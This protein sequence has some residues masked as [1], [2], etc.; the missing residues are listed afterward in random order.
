[1]LARRGR[2]NDEV[3]Q[4]RPGQKKTVCGCK[5]TGV[6]SVLIPRQS[7]F[8]SKCRHGDVLKLILILPYFHPPT[9]AGDNGI[10]RIGFV[11]LHLT[12]AGMRIGQTCIFNRVGGPQCVEDLSRGKGTCMPY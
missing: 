10:Q 11:R 4:R 5:L 3:G 8:S 12:G 6:T 1:M 7:F 2:T 9:N